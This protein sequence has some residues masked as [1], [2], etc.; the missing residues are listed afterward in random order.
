MKRL[1]L[2]NVDVG[3]ICRNVN[4]LEENVASIFGAE[5]NL[6]LYDVEAASCYYI[7]Y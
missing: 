2:R 3:W 5:I 1:V 7:R 4:V 6:S